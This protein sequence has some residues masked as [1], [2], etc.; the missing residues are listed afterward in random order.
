MLPPES[1]HSSILS[2]FQF[3][4]SSPDRDPPHIAPES[5]N[6]NWLS[7]PFVPDP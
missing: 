1:A 3:N 7:I 4:L 2:F 6:G 5:V